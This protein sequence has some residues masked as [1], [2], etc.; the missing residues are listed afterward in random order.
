MRPHPIPD[1]LTT[2]VFYIPATKEWFYTY[3]EY[4][5]RLDFYRQRKFVCEIT[6]NSC[7]SFFQALE[8]E[9]REI[10]GV[11]R[12]FPEALRE[13]ILRFLQFNR[14]TRL[15]HLVDKVYL[16]FRNDYF[17]GETI[18]IK[19]VAAPDHNGGFSGSLGKQR[20]TVREKVQYS[21]PADG[22]T[23]KYLVVRLQDMQ[24]A[25]VT[26]EKISRDRNHFT[27]WLIKT[28]IKLTMTRSSKVGAPWVVKEKYAKKYRIPQE[29]PEDLRHYKWSTPIGDVVFEGDSALPEMPDSEHEA[30][31][32]KRALEAAKKTKKLAATKGRKKSA[33]NNLLDDSTPEGGDAFE[34][35]PTDPTRPLPA[36][37]LPDKLQREL[38]F[39]D[40]KVDS[41]QPTKKNVAEDL[42][43]R[44]DLQNT[45]PQPSVPQLSTNSIKMIHSIISLREKELD[46]FEDGPDHADHSDDKLKLDPE[47]REFYAL[48][49]ERLR[50][51]LAF[52]CIQEALETWS[53]LN[54]YHRALK[55]DTFT[56]DDFVYAMGWTWQ[57]Y[58]DIGR[59]E[60]VD[61]IWCAVLSAFV[62]NEL[63]TN[64]DEEEDDDEVF[65]LLVNL[66][67][68]EIELS[69]PSETTP[70]KEETPNEI[71]KETEDPVKSD[72]DKT[73]QSGSLD[74]EEE[75]EETA[76]NA[77]KIMDYRGTP[78]HDRLRKRN[79]KDGNWQSILLGVLSLVEHVPEYEQLITRAYKLLA[80]PDLPAT[81]ATVLNQFYDTFDFELRMQIL[82][83]LVTLLSGGTIV[84]RYIDECLEQST[85]YRRARLD[86]IRDYKA[87][88]ETAL[89]HHDQLEKLKTEI[90]EKAAGKETETSPEKD[91]KEL[92]VMEERKKLKLNS[93]PAEMDETDVKFSEI[94]QDY[95][96]T[97]EER[98][99]TLLKMEQIRKDRREIERKLVEL[100]S[101]RL[102]LLGKDRLYNRYWWFENNGLPTLHGTSKD[103]ENDDEDVADKNDDDSDVDDGEMIDETYLMGS[104]WV[105]GPCKDDV[106]IHLEMSE[107]EAKKLSAS[108]D[109][110][111]QYVT[112]REE[113][114]EPKVVLDNLK[115]DTIP[116]SFGAL[117]STYGVVFNKSS[118]HIGLEDESFFDQWG[119]LQRDQRH[120]TPVQRKFVEEL[121]SPLFSGSSWRVYTDPEQIRELLQWLNPWG[122][123]ES[124]LRKE[125]TV[126][127]DA[128]KLSMEARKKAMWLASEKAGESNGTKEHEN[129]TNGNGDSELLKTK[130]GENSTSEAES[131][132]GETPTRKRNRQPSGKRKRTNI[133]E[134]SS[135]E[136]TKVPMT[137]E[138][139]RA[140][141]WT[142]S[143]AR[144]ELDKLLYEGGDKGKSKGRKKK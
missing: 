40:S 46:T 31:A 4:I 39:D 131:E 142:N 23:T 77:Y 56:F 54:I 111:S 93:V 134:S 102:K 20:G 95:K 36:H 45:R 6:G 32:L 98:K 104:L 73:S 78:W 135:D 18:Y 19:G 64:Q 109:L 124:Q 1:D 108:S 47:S 117:A 132:D 51:S 123:R 38:D 49:V 29:F 82:C 65:G 42:D 16:T 76:H 9:E 86:N 84:R 105:Q 130:N 44:F 52:S 87:M 24:Q 55:L 41:I 67:V 101:Q 139:N 11:E 21:N 140:L 127:A 133:S 22:L 110:Q 53:F 2:E 94:S 10:K 122:K 58:E 70:V 90:E 91:A 15:D 25:I 143:L 138:L 8:S 61:E 92:K 128:I 115:F 141:E 12:N 57:E 80:P 48:E 120:L 75:E 107:L 74:E 81:P 3:E 5:E 43:I 33:L 68:N 66:P 35:K 37:Y 97:W 63:P 60:L 7:L 14:I 99:E 79:F 96:T 50:K 119:C 100:D 114:N 121:P 69:E 129:L 85:V 71:K 136:E 113:S 83:L 112:F 126:V 144:E 137:R 27:K 30:L 116:T 125:L 13:H 103:E 118:V 26:K 89:G 34:L 59:C 62:S 28:F 17:P 72:V 88:T 106:R